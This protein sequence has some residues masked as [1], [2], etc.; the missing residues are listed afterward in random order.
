MLGQKS[1]IDHE[2]EQVNHLTTNGIWLF[3]CSFV[4]QFQVQFRLT[5]TSLDGD[6]CCRLTLAVPTALL[7][8]LGL[9]VSG[10]LRPTENPL[11]ELEGTHPSSNAAGLLEN[12]WLQNSGPT[13]LRG[14]TWPGTL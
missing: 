6:C 14:M 10:T 1:R 7:L 2:T 13:F 9:L 12:T 4:S 11:T 8:Q 3:T 5:F